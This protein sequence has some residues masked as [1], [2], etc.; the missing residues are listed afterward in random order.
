MEQQK[1]MVRISVEVGSGTARFGGVT[2]SEFF[3]FS[4]DLSVSES[5]S[6]SVSESTPL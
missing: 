3:D 6:E 4:L 1:E 5:T 2:F